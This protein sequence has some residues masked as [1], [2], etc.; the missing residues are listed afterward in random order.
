M[1]ELNSQE[2]YIENLKKI[3]FDSVKVSLEDP[4]NLWGQFKALENEMKIEQ[5]GRNIF[6]KFNLVMSG[7]EPN[8]MYKIFLEFR[9]I[10]NNQYEWNTNKGKWEL[11]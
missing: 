5:R 9:Q 6:P 7:L 10:G 4:E 2:E 3:E 11:G 8:T 1:D